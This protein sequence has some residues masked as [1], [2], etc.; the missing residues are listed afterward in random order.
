MI[1]IK[2]A[3]DTQQRSTLDHPLEHLNACHRRIEDRLATLERVIPHFAD[4]PD[5]ALAALRNA[6]AFLDSSGALHTEDE[7]R[8]VFPRL[9]PKIAKEDSAFLEHLEADHREAEQAYSE[10]KQIARELNEGVSDE[11]VERYREV[12]ARLCSIYR[13]HIAEEDSRLYAVGNEHLSPQEM[14]EIAAEMKQRR[15]L[16]S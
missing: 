11:R 6:F 7:E 1:G 13:R 8:S 16:R 5:E 14:A 2:T 4:R 12:T 15:G 10:L 9:Y 3:G